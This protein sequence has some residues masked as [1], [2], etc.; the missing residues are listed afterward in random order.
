MDNKRTILCMDMD[1]FFVSVEQAFDK[2]LIDKPCAVVGSLERSV[3][4]TSSYLARSLGVKTGMSMYEAKNACPN[5]IF[6]KA[7]PLKY[8]EVSKDIISYLYNIT[9]DV[10]PFS[11]DEAFLDITGVDISPIDASK[12]IKEYIE[13]TFNITATIGVGNNFLLAKQ[14]T[15]FA[16][17]NGYYDMRSENPIDFMD[18]FKLND[19]WGIGR[20]LTEKF[21]S[22]GLYRVKD[23]RDYGEEA[24][25]K[26]IGKS[27]SKV[28]NLILG[29]HDDKVSK[30]QED[31]KSI[32]HSMTLPENISDVSQAYEYLL[33]MSEMVSSRV[34]TNNYQ[35]NT[36]TLTIR[37]K[38]MK[39]FTFQRNIGYYTAFTH[40]IYD[41]VKLLVEKNF[42]ENE[43]IRLLG[44]SLSGLKKDHYETKTVE[45]FLTDTNDDKSKIYKTIDK[46]NSKFGANTISY[47]TVLKC[48][49]R[50][51]KVI[52][53]AW[54][55]DGE[56]NIDFTDK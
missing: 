25:I 3:V 52:S 28:Y 43:S 13:T 26:L 33:Q 36:V 45:D 31:M 50:G 4:V 55:P 34:R 42:P 11:I 18:K 19:I 32:G 6:I 15:Y 2:S 23:V 1:A 21:K 29:V 27:G 7:D 49:R 40:H 8:T 37:L 41:T 5:L 12:R 10:T 48:S 24:L 22:I 20:K 39:T 35:G 44:V 38:D 54:R 51:N 56:R 53:P 16:K 14:A 47:A 9:P 46:I 30:Y 17:P